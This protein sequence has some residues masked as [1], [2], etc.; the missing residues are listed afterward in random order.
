[1][2]PQPP[3]PPQVLPPPHLP[4]P[5]ALPGPGAAPAQRPFALTVSAVLTVTAGLQVAGAVAFVWLL[6]T[7]LTSALDY[8]DPIESGLYHLLTRASLSLQQGLWVP[9]IGLP[10]LAVVAGFCLPVRRA[11]PRLVTTVLGAGAVAW[12]LWWQPDQLVW[13]SVPVGYIALCVLLLWTPAVTGW[14]RS[15]PEESR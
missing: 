7:A 2:P 13:L 14:L 1:Q 8:Q 9:L 3:Q 4:P 12:L 6:L 10:L 11:W 5:Q 15:R